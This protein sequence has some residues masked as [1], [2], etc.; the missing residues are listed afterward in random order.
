MAEASGVFAIL[1]HFVAILAIFNF[2][3]RSKGS[4]NAIFRTC[5]NC[6]RFFL[7]LFGFTEAKAKNWPSQS[8]SGLNWLF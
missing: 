8:R 1:T 2:R 4:K 7:D 3:G 5:E 6:L